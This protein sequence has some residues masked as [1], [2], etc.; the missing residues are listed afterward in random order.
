MLN[1][2][3]AGADQFLGDI[4]Q[5]DPT[6][7]RLMTL[8]GVGPVTA[9]AY[10]AAL[11]DVTRFS[12]P[13]QVTSYLGL[14][15]QEYSSGEHQRRGSVGRAAHPRVQGLLVQAAWRVWRST[16]PNT[17]ALREWARGIGARRGKQVAAVALA[18]RLARILFA[19]WRDGH[20][21]DQTRIR[22][23]R[24]SKAAVARDSVTTA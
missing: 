22:A 5:S 20:D 12:G 21:Y 9:T 19:M 4:A 18:R 24:S 3:L 13:G 15:P 10:V 16:H 7:R 23:S 14:V 8:P 17:R 11:D 2:Q 6:V 1:T